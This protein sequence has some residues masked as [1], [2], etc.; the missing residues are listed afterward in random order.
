MSVQQL[1]DY[2]K[3]AVA[4]GEPQR[5]GI[6]TDG[7]YWIL[8]WP[9]MGPVSTQS[10]NAF[11]LT[12]PDHGLQLF[13]WLRD[14]SQALEERGIP[15]TAEEVQRRL[16]EGPRFEQHIAA[17]TDLYQANRDDPTITL[18][19]DLWRSLLAAALGQV[20]EEEPDL[21]QLFVR[22]TYLS[23]VV[24]LA[25]QAAF[26][27]EIEANANSDPVALLG[28]QLFVDQ[29]GV[30]GVV[31][32]DFFTWPAEVG[33]DEWIRDLAKRIGWFDWSQAGSD[34]ARVL[35]ESVIPTKDRQRLG[36]YYTPDW[37]AREIVDAVVTDPLN[38]RVLDPACG[39]GSFIFA[40]VR[41]YLS[42][43]KAE[44][45]SSAE[46]VGGLLDH[47]IGIDVHPVAV[48]LARATWT[49]AARDALNASRSDG[50]SITVPVYLGD[51]LQL[52][53]RTELPMFRDT[54][55]IPVPSEPGSPHEVDRTLEFPRTLV[56][57]ADRFDGLM[58]NM[59]EII[60][61]GGN[62]RWAL[63]DKD[64]DDDFDRE[65]LE[66]TAA[67]LLELHEEGRD[68]IWA[69]YTRN[70]VRPVALRAA[71]VDVIV[72]NPPWIAHHRTLATVRA[73]LEDLSKGQYKIWPSALYAKHQDMSSLFF[74]RCVDLYLK[75]GGS[76]GMILPHSALQTGQYSAWRTGHWG[77]LLAE[78]NVREPWDLEPVEPNSF[79]PVPACVVFANRAKSKA[80][81]LPAHANRWY[82]PPGGPFRY[83]SVELTDTSSRPVSPY[84]SRARQ[85]ATL[86]PRALLFV[87]AEPFDSPVQAEKV[88]K[89]SPHR[90]RQE[91]KPWKEL[92]LQE[93]HGRVIE[94]EHIVDVH[95]GE[96]VAPYVLLNP[97]KAALPVA[98]RTGEL[99][100]N[101][102]GWYGIEWS[103]LGSRMRRRWQTM[104]EI[105]LQNRNPNTNRT[106]LDTIDFFGQLSLQRPQSGA[107]APIR[108]GYTTS[109]R[110]TAVVVTDPNAVLDT[111]LYWIAVQ[112]EAEG[113]YLTAVVNSTAL[114]DAVDPL[115]GKGQFGS[116][117][118]HKHLW[119]LPIPE[120]DD[121]NDLHRAIAEAGATAAVGA[122]A[123]WDDLRADR[124]ASGKST[125][126]TVAR[127][128]IREWL[129]ESEEGQRVEEL[130]GRL[131]GV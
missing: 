78:F 25:V 124:E 16:G 14:Q 84:G 31:E 95:L 115:M 90:S 61:S 24:G 49:L 131:L 93:L 29:T 121:S 96:T 51:S 80:S 32:S 127:R 125:S 110:P 66:R 26:G 36:E 46:V 88:E 2:I 97:R 54:V 52:L 112:S 87:D 7:K 34:I 89:V 102:E 107:R 48:H 47:V 27:I 69:Y 117:D 50:I 17:L 41:K 43:A 63:D 70:L 122:R 101:K 71:P 28:G 114:Q 104:S 67:T 18:K 123:L 85:G 108:V 56:E 38:Q 113:R 22:H 8:R 68:H 58:T 120:Y 20:V 62:P 9:G 45:L 13:E 130:V 64:I 75:A 74:T 60:R 81:S 91:K 21:D 82:G 129:S 19:R 12:T 65:M 76:V 73:A 40:A 118:L 42:A 59:A 103:S 6:L 106:L 4:G 57:Q 111:K 3:A 11:T 1:D 10:P 128:E 79:F 77:E 55:P 72:G 37:L 30:S 99:A 23:V 5:F 35:Y 119:R 109:G 83:E 94:S 126:V 15:P 98:A 53:A 100:K 92:Q 39:S 86:V 33:G 116:R 105:F 44:G